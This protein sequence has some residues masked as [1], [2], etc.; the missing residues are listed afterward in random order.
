MTIPWELGVVVGSGVALGGGSVGTM[1]TV[2]AGGGAELTGAATVGAGVAA[3]VHPT[4]VMIKPRQAKNGR[5]R[6]RRLMGTSKRT[7]G[8]GGATERPK[9]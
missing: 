7:A 4:P 8:P 6:G 2:V 9:F 1:G 3:A 5:D